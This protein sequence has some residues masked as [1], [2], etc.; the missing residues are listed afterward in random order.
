[1]EEK[2]IKILIGYDVQDTY[3]KFPQQAMAN[4]VD[5]LHN[6]DKIVLHLT[7][8][9]ALEELNYKEKKFLQILKELCENNNWP[10]NKIHI[11]LPN[12]VQ[13]KSV[14]PSIDYGDAA[15]LNNNITQ[16]IFLGL[17]A[18]N[19]KIEK[20]IQKTFGIFIHRSQ[21]DRLLLSSHLYKNYK[22][23]TMQTF[24][25]NL[26]DPAHMIEMGV[27]QLFWLLSCNNKLDKI[28]IQQLCDFIS[29]LPHN[30][31][32][33]WQYTDQQAT[34]DQKL[35]GWYN[36]I[37]LDIVC[38]KMV[39]GQTFFPTEKTARP[40]ATK[41]PFLIMA[42]PNYIKNLRR[43]GFRSF[44]EFWDES[45]DYQQGIQRVESIQRIIDDLAKLTQ[46]QLQNLYQKMTPI[47]EHNYKTYIELSPSIIK[48]V[49]KI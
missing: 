41:T 31:G 40:L 46:E 36:N 43:L 26:E 37:F 2:S 5:A 10:L 4:I 19:I 16:N 21:W 18:E 14:W 35:I 28:L 11:V 17:Q 12:L 1:M 24:R 49:F 34:V 22:E 44:G 38:E 32:I 3:F 33:E 23:I 8:G 6:N 27:D 13:D 25:K 47:L 45:Y 29:S 20:D 9:I 39:T 30:N 42:A 7:E 48:S 15:I